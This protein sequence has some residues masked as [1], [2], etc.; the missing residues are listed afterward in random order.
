[1]SRRRVDIFYFWSIP[2]G[3]LTR[4]VKLTTWRQANAYKE[5]T[6]PPPP[7]PRDG[8][9]CCLVLTAVASSEA[10]VIGLNDVKAEAA[11]LPVS[12]LPI[13]FQARPTGKAKQESIE[14]VFRLMDGEGPLMRIREQTSFDLDKKLWDSGIGLSSWLSRL[15]ANT[16]TPK[17][18]LVAELKQVLFEKGDSDIVELGAGTGIVSLV[19]AALCRS[20][21][22]PPQ[23]MPRI[24]TTDLESSMELMNFDIAQNASLYEDARPTALTL[25]WDEELPETVA[26][27][28]TRGGFNAIVMADVTY[29]TASFP[30]LVQTIKAL[31]ALSLPLPSD[32]EDAGDTHTHKRPLV[33]LAYKQRDPAERELWDM[34]EKEASV[35]LEQV[36]AVAGAGGDAVEIWIGRQSRSSHACMF[37]CSPRSFP[38]PG[39][40]SWKSAPA[41][42]GGARLKT[43]APRPL[44]RTSHS[45]KPYPG[46]LKTGKAPCRQSQTFWKLSTYYNELDG[47]TATLLNINFRHDA[48]DDIARH[49]LSSRKLRNYLQQVFGSYPLDDDGFATGGR[50]KHTLLK[51]DE[52]EIYFHL[53]RQ[54]SGEL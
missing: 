36:G 40:W 47:G 15:S 16:S 25:D 8:A 42:P 31:I 26:E 41:K 20:K 54:P 27:V 24:L 48:A 7:R 5:L 44:R 11:P 29:N 43:T 53:S 49:P 6:I 33:L 23:P 10:S 9:Q 21:S 52:I 38:S 34:L 46:N 51:S 17:H 30:A 12:S 50:H 13:T 4:P 2:A 37:P 18:P 35:Q 45:A 14:R 22:E 19:L 1:I 3:P 39:I 28:G 32:P